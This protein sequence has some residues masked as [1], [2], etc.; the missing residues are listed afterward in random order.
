M[1]ANDAALLNDL[2]QDGG[3]GIVDEVS[4]GLVGEL[5]RAESLR[6]NGPCHTVAA[7]QIGN[8]PRPSTPL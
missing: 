8:R 6:R 7:A 4:P 1:R 5:P 2:A 3:P